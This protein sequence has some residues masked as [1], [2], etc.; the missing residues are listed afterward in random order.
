MGI[1][2]EHEG[3]AGP[4]QHSFLGLC[5]AWLGALA[6]LGLA[7]WIQVGR[8]EVPSLAAEGLLALQVLYLLAWT[9]AWVVPT[10]WISRLVLLGA[11]GVSVGVLA[12]GFTA[13]GVARLRALFPSDSGLRRLEA[14]VPDGFDPVVGTPALTAAAAGLVA[15][16]VGRSMREAS[17]LPGRVGPQVVLGATVLT[18]IV[19]TVGRAVA[20]AEVSYRL[21]ARL[22]GKS[23]GLA[24]AL[25]GIP[26]VLQ[27]MTRCPE[28]ALIRMDR[29]WDESD[30]AAWLD[31][32]QAA[33]AGAQGAL[34]PALYQQF[35]R[36]RVRLASARAARPFVQQLQEAPTAG[37]EPEDPQARTLF[38]MQVLQL[39][40]DEREV[41]YR[42]EH[43]QDPP[44]SPL[45]TH[46]LR[47]LVMLSQPTWASSLQAH[48]ARHPAAVA[49]ASA[50]PAWRGLVRWLEGA[51]L[52]WFVDVQLGVMADLVAQQVLGAGSSLDP[53]R[54]PAASLAAARAR[55]LELVGVAGPRRLLGQPTRCSL[56]QGTPRL[57]AALTDPPASFED[58]RRL[59]PEVFQVLEPGLDGE[60]PGTLLTWRRVALGTP[61]RCAEALL[62]DQLGLLSREVSV[63]LPGDRFRRPTLF[64]ALQ[65]SGLDA[66]A[67]LAQVARLARG[68]RPD[69]DPRE[70]AGPLEA[71][72]P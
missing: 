52:A 9:A 22:E 28:A 5:L 35:W 66:D 68:T 20:W 29:A 72:A 43:E 36:G 11:T 38:R 50:D 47:L 63:R 18:L 59:H 44:E 13:S 55:L 14:L 6:M 33:W 4:P 1:A 70:G 65:A 8:I 41:A 31:L 7:W 32:E 39:F 10:G 23:L 17:G 3:A 25:A 61:E 2:A 57:P 69:P 40:S 51:S 37:W 64:E 71:D 21:P 46:L 15:Y 48:L 24:W 67:V 60:V 58:L 12:F 30:L 27:D 26:G 62:S 42:F 34:R 56:F 45:R 54:D 16:L 49:A 19:G 53:R